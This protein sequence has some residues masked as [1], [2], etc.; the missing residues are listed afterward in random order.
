M[1]PTKMQCQLRIVRRYVR[2]NAVTRCANKPVTPVSVVKHVA[3]V[4]NQPR[5]STLCFYRRQI[6]PLDCVCAYCRKQ[7]VS[8]A[9]QYNANPSV[10]AVYCCRLSIHASAH[11]V[12]LVTDPELVQREILNCNPITWF[13]TQ[14]PPIVANY[15]HTATTF[16]IRWWWLCLWK[17]HRLLR[18][19]EVYCRM[20]SSRTLTPIL[21][22][23]NPVPTLTS[24]FYN[25]H[26]YKHVT[27]CHIGPIFVE[28][29]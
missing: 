13:E 21:C 12:S 3:F 23:L 29:W 7:H 26:K 15:L 14:R 24:Y 1:K 6:S 20:Y 19:P 10:V 16:S 25:I 5:D 11:I 4:G 22:Q 17:V 28:V 18:N 2:P 9:V 27:K 8:N